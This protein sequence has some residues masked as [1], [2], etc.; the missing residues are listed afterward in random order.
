[1]D[2]ETV[3]ALADRSLRLRLAAVSLGTTVERVFQLARLA[4]RG[5]AERDP[6]Q[7]LA[8]IST[9]LRQLAFDWESGQRNLHQLA[10]G[11]L[12]TLLG[13]QVQPLRP[14]LLNLGRHARELARSLGKQVE[15]TVSAGT[16]QLDRRIVEALREAFL[17]LLRNA[18]DHGIE[19]PEVREERGKSK[20]GAVRLEATANGGRVR[21]SVSDDGS[22]IDAEAVAAMARERGLL[23]ADEAARMSPGESLQLLF[24]P[25]FSTR[26]EAGE[27]SG[28]GIGLDAVAE[29][30]R[31]LGGDVAIRSSPG[32]G[33][34][35]T[36]DLPV[37]RSADRV[38][39]CTVG[40]IQVALP[41]AVVRGFL[42][43]DGRSLARYG[44]RNLIEVEGRVLP[45]QVV[46]RLL[47]VD[48]ALGAVL[49]ECQ[50]GGAPLN[51]LVDQV[52]GEEEVLLRPLPPSAG[53]P[54]C[55]DTIALLSSGRPVPVLAP[56]RLRVA[57]EPRTLD[58]S[59]SRRR[60]PLR[61]LLVDDSKVTREMLK[62]LLEDA[63]FVV[64]ATGSAGEALDLL[65][66]HDFDCLLTDVEMPTMDGLQLTRTLRETPRYAHLP[67]VV[68]STRDRPQDH[69]AGLDAGA[70]A[71]IAK[72]RLDARELV[73]L[74]QRVGGRA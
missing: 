49:V 60:G 70:D 13:L 29:V 41:A 28:R 44:G 58:S 54:I 47:G 73:T 25:G 68:V 51:V 72:Q 10:E 40:E 37:A 71:Y 1:V 15:V 16:S 56:H 20:A 61:L 18:V 66:A 43:A 8:T 69:M 32:Q 24:L 63:G 46:G 34:T 30:V 14:H 22:G 7:V 65:A 23:T 31:G 52:V 38:L 53:L 62:R 45:V 26:A 4:E 67:V 35:I 5:L 55:F 33:S 74:I 42:R 17:H 39:V 3:S 57:E 11:Q 36:L 9:S 6:Q 12:N 50:V 64:T 59:R 27:V 48:G 2:A 19:S 21:V